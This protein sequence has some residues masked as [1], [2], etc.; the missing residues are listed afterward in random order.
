MEKTKLH[1]DLE[2][3]S[4]T[5]LKDC[6]VYR[7]VTDPLFEITLMAFAYGDGPVGLIDL[8]RESV[9][10]ELLKDLTNPSLLKIAHNANFERTCLHQRFGKLMDPEQ[11]KCTA[12]LAATMGLPRSLEDVCATLRLSNEKAKSAE[13]YALIRYFCIP[14]KPTQVNGGRVRNLPEH[15]PDKWERFKFYCRQDVVAEREVENRL[16]KYPEHPLEGPLWRMDQRINDRGVRIDMDL[17]ESAIAISSEVTHDL[18]QEAVAITGVNNPK[19]RQQLLDWLN[20]EGAELPNMQKKTIAKAISKCSDDTIKRVLEIRQELNKTSLAKYDAMDRSICP[21]GRVRGSL[22]HYGASRTGRWAGKIIQPQNLPKNELKN[23]DLARR[24]AKARDREGIELLFGSVTSTLSE[25][26]RTAIVPAPGKRFIA[27]DYSAIEARVLAWLADETWRQEV[28]AT[29]GKIYEASAAAM[30]N[31]PL[32]RIKKG[33]PEYALRQKGK[34][35]ELALGYGGA[36][37]ALINMG[38]LDKGLTKEEL[39]E[40]VRLWREANKNIFNFWWEV[41]AAA[42]NAVETQR[43]QKVRHGITIYCNTS[44]LMEIELPCGRRLRY[45]RPRI[46]PSSV[47]GQPGVTYEGRDDKGWG[48]QETYGPKLVE[49]ITQ[50]IARDCLAHSMYQVSQQWDEIVFH[51]HDEMILEVPEAE[52]QSRLDG[53]LGLMKLPVPWAPGLYLKGDG[54]ICDYYKKE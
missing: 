46:A 41:G 28:F 6:G 38:A 3:F 5:D 14:C 25:L 45:L 22:L 33:N 9:P 13:G 49:N 37:G 31:V 1:I 35:A 21:D 19:S 2:T 43:P 48:R 44:A 10:L 12:V 30:F 8:T 11:W 17:V 23:L 29:H 34:V 52:A 24:L 20:E 4:A 50:A 32:E 51:V 39:P 42:L 18:M 27:A 54:Y 7:Y 53:V 15:A 36:S 26:I 40:I 47:T 16:S